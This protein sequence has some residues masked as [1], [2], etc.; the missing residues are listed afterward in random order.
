MHHATSPRTARSVIL[1]H[2]LRAGAV[3][4]EHARESRAQGDIEASMNW[5]T[6]LRAIHELRREQRAVVGGSQANR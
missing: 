4:E 2:G 1:R 5:T 6:I 3:A